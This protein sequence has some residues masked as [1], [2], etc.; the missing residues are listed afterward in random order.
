MLRINDFQLKIRGDPRPPSNVAIEIVY[1]DEPALT[2]M[3]QLIFVKSRAEAEKLAAK[4]KVSDTKRVVLLRNND[5]VKCHHS[6]LSSIEKSS[7]LQSLAAGNSIV[8]TYGMAVGLNIMVKGEP[9]TSVDVVGTRHFFV[10]VRN[11]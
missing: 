8:A 4:L 7:A 11:A 3:A 6:K 9:V 5:Q 1:Q 10:P 2:D